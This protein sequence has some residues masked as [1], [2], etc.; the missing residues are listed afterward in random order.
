MAVEPYRFLVADFADEISV[1][2]PSLWRAYGFRFK[3][4]TYIT[5]IIGGWEHI[6]SDP[7]GGHVALFTCTEEG[8]P[9]EIL[10]AEP[11]MEEG[12]RQVFHID[13]VKM[14]PGKWYM[15]AQGST[16]KQTFVAGQ[17]LWNNMHAVG[18]W[19]VNEMMET[20]GIFSDW[21]PIGTGDF[22]FQMFVWR[23]KD[24]EE[25]SSQGPPEK[26]I[27]LPPTTTTEGIADARPDLGFYHGWYEREL[28]IWSKQKG[29]WENAHKR[30]HRS[31]S[32]QE[33]VTETWAKKKGIWKPIIS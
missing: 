31:G 22:P 18:Y 12:R 4:E 1:L 10:A 16:E 6:Y 2:N 27:G 20:L 29:I 9:L 30:P 8:V 13:P 7:P 17:T 3:E 19:D 21:R 24:G 11:V 15:I 32:W 5:S 28:T 33:P 26:I 14:I 23:H 25:W